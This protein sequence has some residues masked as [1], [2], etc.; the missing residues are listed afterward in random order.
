MGSAKWHEGG[1]KALAAD[2]GSPESL[3]K[4]KE[5][6]GEDLFESIK[7]LLIR[8]EFKLGE[9][10]TAMVFYPPDNPNI[11]YKIIRKVDVFGKRADDDTTKDLEYFSK[12]TKDMPWH[13]TISH[14][15]D[16][17][18]RAYD[19]GSSVGV[20]RAYL[21]FT[22]NG[23]EEGEGY[24]VS[25]RVDVLVMERLQGMNLQDLIVKKLPLPEGFNLDQ[26]MTDLRAFL[27][28]M[29]AKGVTHRDFAER[30]I[31]VNP[32]GRLDVIDFG[33]STEDRADPYIEL[34]ND[35]K[36]MRFPVTD[37]HALDLIEKS[38]REY[39]AFHQELTKN[40]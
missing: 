15:A 18:D 11:C 9:G 24:F 3:E 13:N 34:L 14:E 5:K 8:K 33:R 31:M 20:P 39:Q 22:V 1:E 35:G 32:N 4:L 30:N 10:A 16:L 26:A 6:V 25:D 28:K 40:K 21:T 19:P 37:E 36:K 38:L 7:E 23:D 29:H 17:L 2:A 27:E 12:K